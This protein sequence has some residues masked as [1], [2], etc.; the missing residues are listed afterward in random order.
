MNS[1]ESKQVQ[2]DRSR[3]NVS[4]CIQSSVADIDGRRQPVIED[5][6]IEDLQFGSTESEPHV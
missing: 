6:G 4:E 3:S 2:N 5:Y 1:L